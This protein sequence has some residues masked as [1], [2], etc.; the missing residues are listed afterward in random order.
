[1]KR[2]ALAL[3]LAIGV[4]GCSQIESAV[5][6][7]DAAMDEAAARMIVVQG[8]SI[9]NHPR[10]TALGPVHGHCHVNP[11]SNDVVPTGDNLRQAAYRKYG[12]QAD[13]IVGARAWFVADS[14]S[15]GVS[16]PGTSNGHYECE[17]VAIHFEEN[18][19][20]K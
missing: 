3:A 1:M 16:E 14:E 18:E 9:P 8:P 7:R 2:P 12:A 19:A 5:R 11:E 6:A 15:S 4:C 10:Y 20:T 13:G 17:G